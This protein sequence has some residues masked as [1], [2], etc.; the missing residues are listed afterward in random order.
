V[1]A[2]SESS[3]RAAFR[4]IM[5]DATVEVFDLE[6]MIDLRPDEVEST[7]TRLSQSSANRFCIECAAGT[8]NG[9]ARCPHGTAHD[10]VCEECSALAGVTLALQEDLAL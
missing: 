6:G 7:V 8:C 2:V 10:R 9:R 3:Y 5:L 4:D 1:Q